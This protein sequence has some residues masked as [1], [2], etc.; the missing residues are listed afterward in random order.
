M[1]I[2]SLL[3][4]LRLPDFRNKHYCLFTCVSALVGY[5]F[6]ETL[7]ILMRSV[8]RWIYIYIFVSWKRRW[9]G[10]AQSYSDRLW[11]GRSGDRI[12]VSAKFSVPL[13]TGP[14]AQPASC[15]IDT[16]SFPGVKRPGRCV[17]YPPPSSAEVKWRV[18]VYLYSLSVSSWSILGWTLL[19][20][21]YL[22]KETTSGVSCVPYTGERGTQ[23]K[24]A[25][26]GR[27]NINNLWSH[28]FKWKLCNITAPFFFKYQYDVSVL[29]D[30][31]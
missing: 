13:Q 23:W 31:M 22:V 19:L 14:G 26:A 30:T 28:V 18:E 10:I 24:D 1:A 15:T 6:R 7:F 27:S 20:P 12:P 29:C 11:A 3:G 16:G 21:F 4:Q 9:A 2:S 5:V 8:L 17:D 25:G